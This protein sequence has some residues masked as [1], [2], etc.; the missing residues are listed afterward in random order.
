MP[1]T[2]KPPAKFTP[3]PDAPKPWAKT[4][5]KGLHIVNGG[6]SKP[7]RDKLWKF[8]HPKNGKTE[9]DKPADGDFQ[10]YQR[11]KRFP[12]TAHFNGW[13]SG[14]F[15]GAEGQ[16]K[17]AETY[18]ELYA[19]ALEAVQSVND[20]GQDMGDIPAWGN[21]QPESVAVMRHKPNWGLGNHYDNAHDEGVGMV[22][23]LSISDSDTVPRTFK[24][25]DPP[26]GKQFPVETKD[27]Q[28]VVFGGECYD[29][30]QHESVRNS[31]QSGTTISMTIRLAGVC[32]AGK[33]DGHGAK[34]PYSPGF[35]A[36]VCGY[37][38]PHGA[39]FNGSQPGD[40][41]YRP[42]TGGQYATGAP[43]ALKV[44][45]TRLR[46]MMAAEEVSQVLGEVVDKV[47]A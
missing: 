42:A 41:S 26:R 1:S 25:T 4:R 44:A 30:W 3:L 27:S 18:P 14:K 22:M 10:W 34:S 33:R 8:F 38:G 7:T 5:P 35:S 31:K 43:A 6:I 20:S 11:F 17:F 23:M 36:G 19:A 13:H 21:F 37:K 16:Q 40:S 47:A 28:V 2:V 29:F 12:K 46:A 9:G 15:I 24:F 45:H 32:G 39:C